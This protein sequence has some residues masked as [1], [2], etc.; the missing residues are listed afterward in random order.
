MDNKNI[1]IGIPAYNEEKVIYKVIKNIKKEGY[2]NII[3]V[4]DGSTDKTS[5]FAKK[6][7][8]IVLR[9]II[10][11]KGPGAPT[12]TIIE[13]A[14]RNNY[15]YLVLIDADGQHSPKDIKK[16]LS[17]S[18]KFD[19]IIG[20]RMIGD[21]KNMP[22]IRIIANFVASFVTW[23]FF[24]LFLTDTQSGF[25]VLNKK[26]INKIK[27]KYDTFEFCSEMIGEI[28]SNKLSYKEVPIKVIYTNH[29]MQKGHG[30]SIKNGFRM[31]G[32]F[33]LNS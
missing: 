19:V 7:G 30:Q 26:A 13:Y 20:S 16:L 2:D 21:L 10:N 3:V 4:D 27:I 22:K 29:S 1:L 15:D 5:Q 25:K 24:G 28:N 11:R 18:S 6:A 9:H 33:L 14:K 17:Y 8:A 31:I 23:F 12:A 32:R